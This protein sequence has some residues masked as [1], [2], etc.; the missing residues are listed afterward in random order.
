MCHVQTELVGQGDFMNIKFSINDNF[1][2]T[3]NGTVIDHMRP[4]NNSIGDQPP[5]ENGMSSATRLAGEPTDHADQSATQGKMVDG[6]E[7]N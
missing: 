2:F 1:R 7:R 3:L 6:G 5:T 4:R